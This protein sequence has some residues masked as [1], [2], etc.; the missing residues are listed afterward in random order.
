VSLI[1]EALRKREREKQVTERGFLVVAPTAWAQS[2][3]R[4]VAL[5]FAAAIVAFGLGALVTSWRRP[6]A[7]AAP[8]APAPAAPVTVTAIAHSVPGTVL[9]AP[10]ATVPTTLPRQAIAP[11][12]APTATLAAATHEPEPV[13]TAAAPVPSPTP[14]ASP[15]ALVLQA[16][17]QRDGRPVALISDRLM[18]EGDEFDG[19]R[20]VAIR[21]AEVELEVRGE[22]VT[23]RF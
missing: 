21:D 4:N 11:I 12:P 6:A 22:R 7:P 13:A 18:R 5:T 10:A 3:G 19:V 15:A 20:V 14:L 9:P 16:I 2:R 1:L 23:L 8:A 17:S